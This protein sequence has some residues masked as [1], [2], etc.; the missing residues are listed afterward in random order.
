MSPK[1]ILEQKDVVKQLADMK[2]VPAKS[3][4]KAAIQ[5]MLTYMSETW[6]L[7]DAEHSDYISIMTCRIAN[8]MHVVQQAL[9]KRPSPKWCQ[10]LFDDG[11]AGS[12]AAPALP[13]GAAAVQYDYEWGEELKTACRVRAG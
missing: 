6:K 9:L 11:E 12:E 8:V 7:K 10:Q 3:V 2:P 5:S 1:Q 13:A 4:I